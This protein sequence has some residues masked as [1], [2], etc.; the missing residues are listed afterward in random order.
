[1][2]AGKHT[3]HKTR[4]NRK[5]KCCYKTGEKAKI[6]RGE[7]EGGGGGSESE[8]REFSFSKEE[9][10]SRTRSVGGGKKCVSIEKCHFIRAKNTKHKTAACERYIPFCEKCAMGWYAQ[11]RW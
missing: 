10:R 11:T 6:R 2:V 9:S 4:R 8:T 7:G 3:Q 5:K 1:M